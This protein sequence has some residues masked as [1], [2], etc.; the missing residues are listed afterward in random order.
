MPYRAIQHHR[1]DHAGKPE[2]RN[3][4]GGLPVPV[5]DGG[6]QTFAARCPPVAPCHVRRCPGLVDEHQALGVEVGLAHQ[7]SRRLRMS[8]RL[9]S[10]ACAVSFSA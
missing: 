5:R 1:G 3:K 6:A 9:C 10:A 8:G 4:S 2:A 7:A